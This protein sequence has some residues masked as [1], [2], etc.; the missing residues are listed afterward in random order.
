MSAIQV[1]L[2]EDQPQ[3]RLG[4]TAL[5]DGTPGYR[6]AGAWRTCEDMLARLPAVRPDVLLL[7]IGLPGMS[8]IDGARRAREIQWG[9]RIFTL[10]DGGNQRPPKDRNGL[11]F[12][13]AG[14]DPK[15]CVTRFRYRLNGLNQDWIETD[16]RSIH[17]PS[18]QPGD[19][20][21]EVAAVNDAGS[22]G[23]P[24]G[25]SFSYLP[26]PWWRHPGSLLL[27]A[28]TGV[29]LA[30]S[31]YSSGRSRRLLEVE[32]LRAS[33]AA[34]LHDQVGAGLT[35]IAILSEVA[36]RKAGDL[37]ELARIAATARDLV[38]GIGD[39]VWLVNPQRDSLYELFLRL[40]DSYADLFAY[41]G[42]LL[43]VGDLSPFEEVHLPMEY[44]QDLH[45]LFKEALC[46]ALRHSGCRRAELSV[47]LQGGR[48]EVSLRDDGRGFGP[49]RRN[50]DG[51][52]LETMRRRAGRLR[53]SLTIDSSPEGT[54][55]R[56][57]GVV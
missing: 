20:R 1:A 21:F 18:L 16:Q 23:E 41:N 48:L 40:K 14:V 31:L 33:I 57:V 15:A 10:S 47:S 46:N 2:V 9:Y 4:L 39:I 11:T 29:V 43:E 6:C 27:L 7:D 25:Q 51:E 38:D 30:G 8:G 28:S 44:R 42:A 55:V 34:D 37:P 35:D 26:Y 53:G 36:G 12:S 54:V 49:E 24:V 45:L 3:T 50:G 32:R 22:W 52:G 19:Y 17:Y 56:F 13:F 5:I